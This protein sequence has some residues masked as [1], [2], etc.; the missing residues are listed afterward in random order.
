MRHASD[1][2]RS[3]GA[4]NL[5][6]RGFLTASA[7]AVPALTV[8]GSAFASPSRVTPAAGSVR[9]G[10]QVAAESGWRELAGRR[11]G[12][13]T[14]P[15][16]VLPGFTHVVD[17]VVDGG[18]VDLVAAF[19]PE[20][21]FRGTAQ[22]GG[23]EGDYTDPRTGV[24]VYD[25]YGAAADR[26]AAMYRQ[27]DIDMVVFDIADVGARFYTY[28]WAMYTAMHAAA[29]TG[30]AFVVLDRPNPL[31]G[32]AAG[33]QLDPAY[34]SGVGRQPIVSRHGM[35]IGE[36]ARLFN[37]EF[38]PDEAGRGVDELRVIEVEGWRRDQLFGSTGLPW[39]PPSPN[40]PTIETA[41]VYAGTCLFEGT[42]FS[43]GRGT[44]RPFETIGAPGL[45]WRWAEQL[46][47][48]GLPGVRFRETYFVPSFGKHEGTDCGGVALHVTS[49]A[50]FDPL[51]TAVSMITTARDLYPEQWG[52]RADEFIDR[53]AGSDRL[54]LM[55]DAGASPAEIVESW[56]ADVAAFRAR[57]EP[58]LLYR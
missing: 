16:G 5:G 56:D 29:L 3:T 47:E 36:L 43:E 8:S 31:G 18:E 2:A 14:N 49:P 9:V 32:T 6:R 39:V 26:V 52:W 20:H 15:T 53:L 11:V 51:R 57:R 7:L 41:H 24:P 44:T 23:S 22:A 58:Y 25:V 48:A 13:L 50:E 33:P 40:V 17:A 34:A 45:D 4:G 10:A 27:A 55:V 46:N 54:R 35:T 19:G 42:L 28:I 37:A 30:T 12:I 1:P 38:L 21:G